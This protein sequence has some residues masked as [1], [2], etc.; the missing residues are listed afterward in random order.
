MDIK[1]KKF[2]LKQIFNFYDWLIVYKF[3][4]KKKKNYD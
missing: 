4:S 2:K 3:L 1:Q